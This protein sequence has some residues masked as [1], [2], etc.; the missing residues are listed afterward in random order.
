ML[1][2]IQR[3][4]RLHQL[5]KL[6]STGSAKQCASKLEISERQLYNTLELM[7]ALGAPIY[8]DISVGS[9]CYEYETEWSFGFS[10]KLSQ[11]QMSEFN[12]NGIIS[13]NLCTLQFYFSNNT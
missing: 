1:K 6:K 7:K 5:I 13:R 9:Y 4:E 10:R 2:Q 11:S 8:F 3:I 12:A